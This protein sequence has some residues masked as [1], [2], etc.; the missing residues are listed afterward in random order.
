MNGK[1]YYYIRSLFSKFYNALPI[2]S[3]IF[4]EAHIIMMKGNFSSKKRTFFYFK[5]FLE[6][7][8]EK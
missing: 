3:Q 8:E 2:A 1:G 4:S 6:N 7:F 5:A